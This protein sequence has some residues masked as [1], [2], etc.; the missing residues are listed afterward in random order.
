MI[1]HNLDLLSSAD[2]LID[3]G[4]GSGLNGGEIMAKGTPEEIAKSPK[5]RT[6]PYLKEHLTFLKK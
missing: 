3:L 1:E 6:A 5:S 2:Y 4:P